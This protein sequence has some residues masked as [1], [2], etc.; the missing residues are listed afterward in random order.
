MTPEELAMRVEEGE[1]YKI[2]IRFDGLINEKFIY[3]QD[4]GRENLNTFLELAR[5]S[6]TLSHDRI[7]NERQKKALKRVKVKGEITNKESF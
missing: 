2:E 6:A 4:F 1:G 7:L 3:P 5:L